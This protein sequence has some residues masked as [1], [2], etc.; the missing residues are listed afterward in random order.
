[1][2]CF[3]HAEVYW[4][5]FNIQSNEEGS[6]CDYQSG[7]E[8]D[9]SSCMYCRE[10]LLVYLAMVMS[11]FFHAFFIINQSS[12]I[13]LHFSMSQWHTHF[14]TH[15]FYYTNSFLSLSLFLGLDPCATVIYPERF[16]CLKLPTL[17][18]HHLQGDMIKTFKVI[19][20]VHDSA[21]SPV[22]STAGPNQNP[23]RGHPYKLF[24]R[25]T[26]KQKTLQATIFLLKELLM[27]GTTSKVI[28]WR[29]QVLRHLKV[30]LTD[31]GGIKVLHIIMR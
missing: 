1:M 6:W 2:F 29:L 27:C 31:T 11:A 18:Y 16:K 14:S 15:P 12:P 30:G 5:A 25:R 3:G 4:S 19:R 24:K 7:H 22:M 20:G 8:S 10:M 9:L 13:S 17:A 21:S 28:L 23:I 26:N